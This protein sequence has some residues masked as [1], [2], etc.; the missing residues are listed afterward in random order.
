MMNDDQEETTVDPPATANLSKSKST[1][2]SSLLGGL[3][4]G[5][6]VGSAVGAV[7][8]RA[9]LRMSLRNR[10][11]TTAERPPRFF[12]LFKKPRQMQRWGESQGHPH[13]NWFDLFFDLVFVGAAFQLG[14]LLKNNVDAMGV[15]YFV[16][17]FFSL[18]QAWMNKLQYDSRI[19]ADDVAH[20]CL[21]MTEALLVC[22]AALHIGGGK[23]TTPVEDMQKRET[24]HA[25]GFSLCCVMLRVLD[26]VRWNEVKQ[27]RETPGSIAHSKMILKQKLKTALI[28]V[29]AAV[30]SNSQWTPGAPSNCAAFLWIL[31]TL[32]E[33]HALTVRIL[34]WCGAKAS[35][36]EQRIPMNIEFSLHRYG[37]WIMLMVG[38]SMLSLVVGAPL[39]DTPS[40][41]AVFSCGFFSAAALQF[42]HYSTQ[43]F[44]AG[45]HAMR[46]DAKAGLLWG[47]SLA[48]YSAALI[49]FGVALKVLLK[50]HD[51]P[52]KQ[53]YSWLACGSLA[54]SYLLMQ[55]MKALHGGT[56]QF[57]VD[58]GLH[59]SLPTW[60]FDTAKPH[61]SSDGRSARQIAAEDL[62]S[63][64]CLRRRRLIALAKLLL[65]LALVALPLAN[66]LTLFLSATLALWCVAV[67][68]LEVLT[69]STATASH[70]AVA[71][72][73]H[74]SEPSLHAGGGHEDQE[75]QPKV[76]IT[77]SNERGVQLGDHGAAA[78]A[79][80]DLAST[81][82]ASTV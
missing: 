72:H 24:G 9:S 63:D 27:A 38:E 8:R 15:L 39:V 50:Y 11:A 17:I 60:L 67:V 2:G 48:Y 6:Q 5:I 19:V 32:Y 10:A 53:K 51:K 7:F 59:T 82:N 16:A 71:H 29:G 45:A 4:S 37:E 42:L 31:A 13:T 75:Q 52:L 76:N 36:R 28:F 35:S 70:D 14:T 18:F 55:W 49:A 21:D 40:F 41:Y 61:R 44:E 47:Q 25:W 54:L 64:E 58:C 46:R 79:G 66:M 23:T 74:T 73:Q 56:D 43:P 30:V 80:T 20:K 34:R 33:Q 57:V 68:V 3:R 81:G 69:R 65:L 26:A 1:P 62:D 12:T 77:V 78:G 22:A